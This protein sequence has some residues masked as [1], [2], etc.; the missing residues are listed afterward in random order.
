MSDGT[1]IANTFH[2]PL[3]SAWFA[4]H[5]GGIHRYH[6]PGRSVAIPSS[7][8]PCV[9]CPYWWLMMPELGRPRW[10]CPRP[11]HPARWAHVKAGET[12]E[13]KEAAEAL[14]SSSLKTFLPRSRLQT[15]NGRL[16]E[17]KLGT[18]T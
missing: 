10:Y 4:I 9:L 5:L 13:A 16:E 8:L 15:V 11:Q 6:H 3:R 2:S 1:K 14:P 12:A 18:R 7:C 17:N